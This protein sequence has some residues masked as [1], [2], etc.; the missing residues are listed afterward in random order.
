MTMLRVLVMTLP[1]G[2]GISRGP[3]RRLASL[4]RGSGSLFIIAV[5][6]RGTRTAVR[7]TRKRTSEG[8]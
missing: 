7:A 5:L 3:I 2:G 4:G 1:L 8:R 6:S